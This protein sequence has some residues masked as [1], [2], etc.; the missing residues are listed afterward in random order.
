M[1]NYRV[2]DSDQG[3]KDFFGFVREIK[4]GIETAVEFPYTEGACLYVENLSGNVYRET[5]CLVVTTCRN[6]RANP[7]IV[8]FK[9][10][11]D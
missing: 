11:G 8:Y 1:V 4:P 3:L 10:I 2:A 5:G 9:K 6:S 7:P